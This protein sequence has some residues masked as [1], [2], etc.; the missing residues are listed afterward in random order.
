MARGTEKAPL[1]AYAD[2]SFMVRREFDLLQKRLLELSVVLIPSFFK[3]H[4]FRIGSA[5]S[6][7]LRCESY[8]A[9]FTT[10]LFR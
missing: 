9:F 5:T 3:G 2:G 1:F 6:A 4:S 7:A 10:L 8:A